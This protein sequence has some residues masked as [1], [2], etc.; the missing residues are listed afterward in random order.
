MMP[1]RR[2]HSACGATASVNGLNGD[3]FG[4]KAAAEIDALVKRRY[5]VAGQ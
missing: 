4:S 3:Q 1:L 2:Q 5:L